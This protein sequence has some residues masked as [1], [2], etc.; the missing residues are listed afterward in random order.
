MKGKRRNPR[1][2]TKHEYNQLHKDTMI[3]MVWTLNAKG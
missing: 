3:A 1:N 2:Y